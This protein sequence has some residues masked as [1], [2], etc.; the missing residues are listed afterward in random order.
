MTT[1]AEAFFFLHDLI[2]SYVKEK[3]RVQVIQQGGLTPSQQQQREASA[4]DTKAAKAEPRPPHPC[5]R[6]AGRERLLPP[7]ACCRILEPRWAK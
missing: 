7:D 5:S 6:H 2:A 3:E 1:D 4:A